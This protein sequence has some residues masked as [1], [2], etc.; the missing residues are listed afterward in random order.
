VPLGWFA[1]T[2]PTSACLAEHIRAKLVEEL[3]TL[4]LLERELS[5]HQDIHEHVRRGAIAVAIG[6]VRLAIDALELANKE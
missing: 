3:Q 5:S 6:H 4:E 2:E 1:V